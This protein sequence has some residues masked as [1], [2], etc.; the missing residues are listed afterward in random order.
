MDPN[1]EDHASRNEKCGTKFP[2][3]STHAPHHRLKNEPGHSMQK[4]IDVDE[5][6]A[7]CLDLYPLR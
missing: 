7:E 3:M 6:V 4:W 5:H 1:C 2:H